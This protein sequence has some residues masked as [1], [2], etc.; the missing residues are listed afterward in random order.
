MRT[1]TVNTSRFYEI[2]IGSGLLNTIGQ[3]ILALGNAER[4]CIVSDSNVF[5][6]YGDCVAES[7]T[8]LGF[9]VKSYVFPAG[10]Q[11]KNPQ[12]FLSLLNA[13]AEMGLTRSDMIVALGGGVVGDLAG[14]AAACYMRGIRF[15][16]VPTTLLAVVDSSVGGKTAIDLPGGKNMAGAF[17]QPSLVLCDTQT[18]DTL[19]QEIY[20]EGCAEV[21]KYGILYDPGLFDALMV[22][23]MDFNREEVISRCITWKR[24]VVM[25]D[26][27]D[28]GNRMKLNLG[29]T[30]GHSIES[31]SNFQISHG[32]GVSI[33]MAMAARASSHLGF[34]SSCSCQQILAILKRFQLPTKTVFSPEQIYTY[35]LSDKKRNGSFMRMVIPREIG[36]CE[37][38]SMPIEKLKSFIEA[39]F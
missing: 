17:W 31:L 4:V 30:L 28:T 22:S 11:Y 16:Q 23:G 32:H 29:H 39:G 20:R 25:E 26:E 33:G 18:L 14:F 36:H 3:E 6:I 8:D 5:P 10:E 7:L 37:I 9:S 27:F 24:N 21:I 1:V 12:T 15:V 34:C 2:K 19:P 35:T 13:F 38:L